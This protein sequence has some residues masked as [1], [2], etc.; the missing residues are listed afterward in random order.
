[1]KAKKNVILFVAAAALSLL[2]MPNVSEASYTGYVCSAPY[3]AIGDYIYLAVYSQ[4]NCG[5]TYQGTAYAYGEDATAGDSSMYFPHEMLAALY[6]NLLI[7]AQ[8]DIQVTCYTSGSS[9]QT[10][11]VYFKP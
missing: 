11:N 1:M 7:A 2:L 9:T 8:D 6:Q 10:Y 5:G 4:P 3:F